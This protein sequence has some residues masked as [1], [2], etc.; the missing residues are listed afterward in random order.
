MKYKISEV[1]KILNIPIDTIR[2][3]EKKDIV[4]P[5]KDSQN[6]YRFYDAWDINF[7]NEYKRLRSFD[8]STSE[9]REIM[10]HD[11]LKN[12]IDRIDE[13]QCY[14]EER[15]KYYTMLIQKNKEY[16]LSLKN[17]KS[18]LWKCTF[19]HCP[20]IYYFIHRFNYQYVTMNNFDGLFE[21]W[22]NY[23]P[24]VEPIVEIQLEAIKS[25]EE[26]NDYSWGFSI[27]KE[28]VDAFNIQLNNKVKHIETTKSV[29]TVICA[30]DKGSFS[31]A[32]L[33]KV[34]EFIEENNYT[35]I[36][37][38]VGNLLTRV[39]EPNGYCRYI[40]VWLPVEKK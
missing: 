30:G 22:L 4:N 5:V 20:E 38:V 3:L 10:H 33:D 7:L 11:N 23:F 17:I 14:F 18:N 19:M 25:R 13:R 29:Y 34:L 24:F 40:E 27:K 15:L 35:L 36:G 8:F 26:N 39:H 37:N 21:S 12:F 28:Y 32:L 9:V 6:N 31:L 2:Y 1:S 16:R